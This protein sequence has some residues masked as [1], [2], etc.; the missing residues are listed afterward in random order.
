V[1]PDSFAWSGPEPAVSLTSYTRAS[2]GCLRPLTHLEGLVGMKH[3]KPVWGVAAG[4]MLSLAEPAG[5]GCHHLTWNRSTF[6]QAQ[7]GSEIAVFSASWR[8]CVFALI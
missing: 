4:A 7:T 6:H 1:P 3:I 5:I 8:L 2:G